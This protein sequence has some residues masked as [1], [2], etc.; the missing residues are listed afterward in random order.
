LKPCDMSKP[1]NPS[2]GEGLDPEV[3]GGQVLEV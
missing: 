3:F 1:F 2:S